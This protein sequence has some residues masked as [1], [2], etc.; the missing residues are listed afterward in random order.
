[1]KTNTLLA[2]IIV[3]LTILI[4]LLFGSGPKSMLHPPIVD[5]MMNKLSVAVFTKIVLLAIAF[6]AIFLYT[7]R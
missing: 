7:N 3:L 1:M 4:G 5:I 2:I 6:Y